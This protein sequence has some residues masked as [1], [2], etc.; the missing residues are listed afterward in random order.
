MSVKSNL[1]MRTKI[2]R[3]RIEK[4]ETLFV[5]TSPDLKGLLVAEHSRDE[6]HDA[7][8]KQIVALYAACGIHVVVTDAEDGCDDDYEPFIAMPTEIARAALESQAH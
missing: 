4:K 6:V 8:L 1:S 7:I 5:A 2:V 3:V